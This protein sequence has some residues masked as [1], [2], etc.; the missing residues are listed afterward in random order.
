[1]TWLKLLRDVA[2]NVKQT[3]KLKVFSAHMYVKSTVIF[4][5]ART[6]GAQLLNKH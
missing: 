5:C 4:P 6:H 3:N 2:E 1:M